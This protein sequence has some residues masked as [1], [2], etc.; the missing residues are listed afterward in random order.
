MSSFSP[1]TAVCRIS[2][3]CSVNRV[4]VFFVAFKLLSFS[5]SYL[6]P[7][8]NISVFLLGSSQVLVMQSFAF[9]FLLE[10]SQL[11]IEWTLSSSFRFCCKNPIIRNL[12]SL[13]SGSSVDVL[14]KGDPV[15]QYDVVFSPSDFGQRLPVFITSVLSLSGFHWHLLRLEVH[16]LSF[17]SSVLGSTAVVFL[18]H[19][20][21]D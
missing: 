1:A 21:R 4:V 15:V 12:N 18:D 13:S 9:S 5:L 3:L 8:R 11:L 10:Q 16:L 7:A 20:S 14:L 17:G 19:V 6:M 2:N